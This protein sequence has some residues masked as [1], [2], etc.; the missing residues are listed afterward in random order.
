MIKFLSF[1][2]VMYLKKYKEVEVRI[3]SDGYQICKRNLKEEAERLQL[4]NRVREQLL[5]TEKGNK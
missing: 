1:S 5:D 3:N 2:L 4:L